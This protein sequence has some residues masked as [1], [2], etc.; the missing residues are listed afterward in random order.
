VASCFAT[1]RYGVDDRLV[2]EVDGN[3]WAIDGGPDGATCKRVRSKP[4]LI[5]D[6]ASLGALLLGGVRPSALAAGRRLEAR[7]NGSLRRGDA[8]FLTSPAPHC[9]TAY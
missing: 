8:F 9:Q 4:D 3:R 2:V 5:T 7:N 6:T 1:R